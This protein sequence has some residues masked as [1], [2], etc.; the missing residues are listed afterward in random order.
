[1]FQW[2]QWI[3]NRSLSSS[4]RL[5][6]IIVSTLSIY[7]ALLRT[8]YRPSGIDT[9][10][11]R[12]VNTDPVIDGRY[13]YHKQPTHGLL[14]RRPRISLRC[15]VLKTNVILWK[16]ARS[17]VP[18]FGRGRMVLRFQTPSFVEFHR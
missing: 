2:F 13:K 10:R 12:P 14:P 11:R 18:K 8:G 15:L 16:K 4:E 17:I 7:S 6:N 1:M 3:P 5:G 9:G